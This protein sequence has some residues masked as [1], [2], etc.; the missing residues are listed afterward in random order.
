MSKSSV[1]LRTPYNYDADQASVDSGLECLDAT[2][3]QQSMCEECDINVIVRNF[4]VT[5]QLPQGVRVPTYGDFVGVGDYQTALE[6]L[7][8]A[9]DSFM[10]M[11]AAVRARFDHDAGA[12]VDFCS[13]PANID[14]LRSLG[15]A[16]PKIDPITEAGPPIKPVEPVAPLATGSAG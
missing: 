1:F 12:F 8:A 3:A 14:E 10:Q 15:L 9:E 4:G 16:V 2:R 5:G 11:P 6:A 13:D 7:S